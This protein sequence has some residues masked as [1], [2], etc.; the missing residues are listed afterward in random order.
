MPGREA[1]A[2]PAA[3]EASQQ[4]AG[5]DQRHERVRLHDDTWRQ[6]HGVGV[7]DIEHDP[8]T[9]GRQSEQ[10]NGRGQGM[11]PELWQPRTKLPQIRP[12]LA[13]AEA[14]LTVQGCHIVAARGSA[15][16]ASRNA[17]RHHD[18]AAKDRRG[19]GEV[20][21]HRRSIEGRAHSEKTSD[22]HGIDTCG[23]G[24]DGDVLRAVSEGSQAPKH[25]RF[26]RSDAHAAQ[27]ISDH[28]PIH[29]ARV[30]D[31]DGPGDHEDRCDHQAH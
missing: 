7:V 16:R 26:K 5:I 17:Q 14:A 10:V 15:C 3:C 28:H 24:R 30:E 13:S 4:V 21:Q 9:E 20:D 19:H 18:H 6:R 27:K 11:V 22:D 12:Q 2:E 8:R 29:V 31:K 1:V 23:D 25:V